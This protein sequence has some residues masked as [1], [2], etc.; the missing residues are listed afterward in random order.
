MQTGTLL[1]FSIAHIDY[2]SRTEGSK[3]SQISC[4]IGLLG[5]MSAQGRMPVPLA[6]SFMPQ[7]KHLQNLAKQ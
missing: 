5:R 6:A 1:F 3:N 4:K 7:V 2:L